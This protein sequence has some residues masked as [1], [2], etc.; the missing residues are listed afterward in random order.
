[1][2][3]T[4]QK[5]K[6]NAVPRKHDDETSTSAS[7]SSRTSDSIKKRTSK[8]KSKKPSKGC[9]A[10]GANKQSPSN[11]AIAS[12]WMTDMTNF[13]GYDAQS[14]VDM[15]VSYYESPEDIVLEDGESYSP[16]AC[17]QILYSTWLS[18]PDLQFPYAPIKDDPKDPNRVYIEEIY[19]SG[20][21]KGVPYTL[22]PGVLPEIPP[23]G[24]YISNDEQRFILTM[25]NGKIQKCEVVALG[26]FTGFAGLYTQAVYASRWQP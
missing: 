6:D 17:A 19:V 26:C 18:F 25:N 11:A 16:I 20:T 9:E 22:L 2:V 7:V 10:N 15:W 21:H 12:E 13:E 24:K 1:M 14:F 23:S 4:C 3:L 5:N 8:N